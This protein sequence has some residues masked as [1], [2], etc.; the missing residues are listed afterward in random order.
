MNPNA[1]PVRPQIFNPGEQ[2]KKQEE[3][4]ATLVAPPGK[5]QNQPKQQPPVRPPPLINPSI[6]PQ[7][8][9]PMHPPPGAERPTS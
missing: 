4:S 8:P 5:P 9:G 3:V 6:R 7:G 2:A 1:P